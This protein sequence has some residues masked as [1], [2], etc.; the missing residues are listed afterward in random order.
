M[1]RIL[2]CICGLILNLKTVA[3]NIKIQLTSAKLFE[4]QQVGGFEKYEVTFKVLAGVIEKDVE[5]VLP[6][7]N[8]KVVY[9]RLQADGQTLKQGQ[10]TPYALVLTTVGGSVKGGEILLSYELAPVKIPTTKDFGFSTNTAFLND[11]PKEFFGTIKQIKGFVKVGDE[12]EYLNDRGKRDTGKIIAINLKNEWS[13][14]VIFAGI[15]DDAATVTIVSANGVDFTNASVSPKGSVNK[16]INDETAISN[17]N[18]NVKVFSVEASLV[19]DEMKLTIHHLTKYNPSPSESQLEVFK[20]D[21][22]LDYYIVDATIENKTDKAIDGGEYM[23]RLNFFDKDG[24]SADEVLRAFKSDKNSTAAQKD[25]DKVDTG[26]FG[27]TSKIRLA[28]VMVM[29]QSKFPDYDTKYKSGVEAINKNIPPRQKVRS[30]MAT[31]IGVPPTYKIENIGTWK[32]TFFNK[33]N[34]MMMP[35]F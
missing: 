1:L 30:E 23:L 31:I 25:A 18:N 14:P 9:T 34:L 10:T 12:I 16:G 35:I 19:N 15:P 7:S 4:K 26:V 28:Q 22:S 24:K 17:K 20:V 2:V 3:Q 32:G 8:G 27:G 13:V 5:L 29:Y 11:N 21:Y 33:K 6:L